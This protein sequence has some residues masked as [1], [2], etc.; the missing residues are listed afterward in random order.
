MR[1]VITASI[2]QVTNNKG[3]K[4]TPKRK[5]G[6]WQ[7]GTQVYVNKGFSDRNINDVQYLLSGYRQK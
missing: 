1:V 7:S 6:S 5:Q 2:T 3:M 4:S